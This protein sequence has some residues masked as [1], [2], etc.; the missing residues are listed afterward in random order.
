MPAETITLLKKYWCD[1]L[2]HS[3]LQ[4]ALRERDRKHRFEFESSP[5]LGPFAEVL[6]ETFPEAKFVLTV[7]RPRPWLRSFVDRCINFPRSELA[8][9]YTQLRDFCFEPPPDQYPDEEKVLEPY[10]CHTLG[11]F[12]RYWAWHNRLVLKNI[13]T[14]RL[15]VIRTSALDEAPSRLAQFF[16]IDANA[17]TNPGRQNGSLDRHHVLDYVPDSYIQ[18]LIDKHCRDVMDALQI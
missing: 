2:S 7:R 8:K 5:Y 9:P 15:Q 14:S 17:L 10:N 4:S 1:D 12:L 6:P 18:R 16:G 3:E 11:N 13:P